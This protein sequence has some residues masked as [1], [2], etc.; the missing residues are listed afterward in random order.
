[1]KLETVDKQINRLL[2]WIK[3]YGFEAKPFD[4]NNQ[5]F[6]GYTCDIRDTP[7]LLISKLIEGKTIYVGYILYYP[8]PHGYTQTY[9]GLYST[10]WL[11]TPKFEKETEKIAISL[12][13][14]YNRRVK[15]LAKKLKEIA[16][17]PTNNS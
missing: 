7:I 12:L 17:G 11:T 14:N 13:D 10:H 16:Y 6:L 9:H 15:T 2:M 3:L 5:T 4:L 1:M 8:T